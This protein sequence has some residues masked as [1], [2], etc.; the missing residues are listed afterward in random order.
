MREREWKKVVLF[1]F[2][3]KK[4]LEVVLYLTNVKERE[5]EPKKKKN[6]LKLSKKTLLYFL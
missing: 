4:K 2:Y 6:C 3:S 1:Y 5:G